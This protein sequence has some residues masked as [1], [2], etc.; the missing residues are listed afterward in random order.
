MQSGTAGLEEAGVT[1]DDQEEAGVEEDNCLHPAWKLQG[2][3]E[4][5][6]AGQHHAQETKKYNTAAIIEI[7]LL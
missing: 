5:P 2:S 6:G 3:P 1:G 7:Y 4:D